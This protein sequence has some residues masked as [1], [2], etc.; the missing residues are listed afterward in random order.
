MLVAMFDADASANIA[1][2]L[3]LSLIAV[4]VSFNV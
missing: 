1:L 3:F 2:M 4:F